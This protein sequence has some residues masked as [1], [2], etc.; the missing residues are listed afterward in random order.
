MVVKCPVAI[1]PTI[2]ETVETVEVTN[3]SLGRSKH[4]LLNPSPIMDTGN[5]KLTLPPPLV[6][7]FQDNL[8]FIINFRQPP[9]QKKTKKC[10]RN[11]FWIFTE[12]NP[13]SPSVSG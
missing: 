2:P 1:C 4:A 7:F 11:I 10:N 9:P 5:E 13:S 8:I 6:L 12:F 3:Y